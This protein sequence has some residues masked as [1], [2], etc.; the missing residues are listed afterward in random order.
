MEDIIVNSNKEFAL[1]AVR[2]QLGLFGNAIVKKNKEIKE[3]RKLL[4]ES[5]RERTKLARAY[6]RKIKV[7]K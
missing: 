4:L 2:D 6:A 3:L 7:L 1:K 5:N